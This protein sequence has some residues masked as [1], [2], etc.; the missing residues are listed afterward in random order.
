MEKKKKKKNKY[1]KKEDEKTTSEPMGLEN[2][3]Y[4]KYER[5]DM[6]KNIKNIKQEIKVEK[7]LKYEDIKPIVKVIKEEED[8]K[9]NKENNDDKTIITNNITTNNSIPEIEDPSLYNSIKYPALNERLIYN[10]YQLEQANMNFFQMNKIKCINK[11]NQVMNVKDM[12]S[13]SLQYCYENGKDIV[14]DI[15]FSNLQGKFLEYSINK[16]YNHLVTVVIK[17]EKKRNFLYKIKIIADE[18]KGF[19]YLL[20]KNEYGAY[21]VEHLLDYIDKQ[22]FEIIYK[23]LT[24]DNHFATLSKGKNGNHVLQKLIWRLNEDDLEIL[25][26]D[27]LKNNIFNYCIDL[28]GCRI[29]QTL[30]EKCNVNVINQIIIEIKGKNIIDDNNGIH[31]I[32]KLLEIYNINKNFDICFIYEELNNLEIYS[33]IFSMEKSISP[34]ICQIIEY[35]LEKGEEK[36]KEKLINKLIN[37]KNNFIQLFSHR[38]GNHVIQKVYYYSDKEIKKEIIN[39][40]NLVP[41]NQR[42]SPYFGFSYYYICQNNL[43]E[44][45]N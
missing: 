40:L 27:Q 18:L 3:K 41:F 20:S 2:K 36:E 17:Y 35:I 37:E 19:Y 28:Y 8:E 7:E 29:I 15:I 26:K 1:N 16:Y 38:C 25:F 21:V 30:L 9:Q 14:R 44:N 10:M 24:K 22:G 33:K 11:K 23:E 13:S 43:Y 39:L 4:E 31:V 32:Q 42:N 6:I 5:E 45:I 12:D 34:S